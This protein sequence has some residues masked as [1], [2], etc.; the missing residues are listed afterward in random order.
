MTEHGWPDHHDDH[1]Y[2][3]EQHDP[4]HEPHDGA[5]HEVEQAPLPDDDDHGF[6]AVDHPPLPDDHDGAPPHDAPAEHVEA[7]DPPEADEVAA[8]PVGTDPDAL[9]N[10]GTTDTADTAFPPTVDVGPLPEPVDGFPWIDTGSLGAV[11]PAAAHEPPV[12]TVDPH[13]LA[14]YAGADLPP[15]ADPWAVLADSEDPATSALAR[16]WSGRQPG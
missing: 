11:D 14:E 3:E 6:F 10:Y 1:G 2:H 5:V 7:A 13:E 8:A 9:P 12:D 16:W 4:L 15:A